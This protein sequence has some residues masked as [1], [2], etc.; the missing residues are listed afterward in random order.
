MWIPCVLRE[1]VN[2]GVIVW[3]D[4]RRGATVKGNNDGGR[5][6]DGVML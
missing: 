2:V 4:D 5:S 3:G 1:L 6:S